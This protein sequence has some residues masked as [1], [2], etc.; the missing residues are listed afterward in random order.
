MVQGQWEG[1]GTRRAGPGEEVEAGPTP[2]LRERQTLI[3]KSM[4]R[5]QQTLCTI[6]VE[7]L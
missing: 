7:L 6:Y 1:L 2:W 5:K 3:E 4:Y